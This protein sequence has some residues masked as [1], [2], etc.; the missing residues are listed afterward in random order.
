M[1][2]SQWRIWRATNI[3]VNEQLHSLSPLLTPQGVEGVTHN[4]HL[5][6][7]VGKTEVHLGD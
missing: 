3:P 6:G 7:I 4:A 2:I 1:F 5:N